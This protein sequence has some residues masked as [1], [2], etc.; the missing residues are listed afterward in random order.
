MLPLPAEE[1]EVNMMKKEFLRRG[2]WRW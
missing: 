1:K 2:S